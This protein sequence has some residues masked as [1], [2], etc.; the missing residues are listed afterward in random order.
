[1]VATLS[2]LMEAVGL[3]MISS[4]EGA[5]AAAG[6]WVALDKWSSIRGN[7]LQCHCSPT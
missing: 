7:D 6:A 4:G 2:M 3:L 5:M 1:M